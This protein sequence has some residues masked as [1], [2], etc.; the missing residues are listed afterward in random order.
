MQAMTFQSELGVS[1]LAHQYKITTQSL[2]KS[3][4]HP[5]GFSFFPF[6]SS[7]INMEINILGNATIHLH[8][9]PNAPL[10]LVP[11]HAHEPINDNLVREPVHH[12]NPAPEPIPP[13]NVPA[14][15]PAQGVQLPSIVQ[16]PEFW[17]KISTVPEHLGFILSP[18]CD[19]WTI[20]VTCGMLRQLIQHFAPE[21]FIRV[22]T[23]KPEM[24]GLFYEHVVA[25]YGG[26]YGYQ[27]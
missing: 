22:R 20:Q 7:P 17:R 5:I 24:I 16:N 13:P 27:D 6:E 18:R 15:N 14:P 19:L 8:N 11:N 21:H 26:F 25:V 1:Q 9:I 23:R 4:H 2:R 10:E 12:V 3:S